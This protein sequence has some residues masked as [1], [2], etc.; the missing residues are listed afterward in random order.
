MYLGFQ[1]D[2]SN[3]VTN[4]I[5]VK[6]VK[7]LYYGEITYNKLQELISSVGDQ[8]Q[9]VKVNDNT[10]FYS[11]QRFDQLTAIVEN[12]K[13]VSANADYE[14]VSNAYNALSEALADFLQNGKNAGGEPEKFNATDLT[15]EK[16]HEASEFAR[17]DESITSRFAKPKYWTVEN[18]SIP[19]GGS[20]TKQGLDKYP[21]Y[22]C[23]MLGLWDD[24]DSNEEGDLANARIYQRI[25]LD[26]GRYYFGNTFQTRYNLGRA[27]L[28]AASEPVATS[29]M[30]Q[31]SLAWLNI[32]SGGDDN[33]FNGIYFTLDQT[34]D[35]CLGFQANLADGSGQQEFRANKVVLYGYNVDTGIE[36][37]RPNAAQRSPA[38]Y[39]SLSG[40]RLQQAPQHGFYIVRE[41]GKTR[42]MI[43]S[44]QK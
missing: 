14:T 4:N 6:A 22:D 1:A 20:G 35:V 42:K 23:L 31:Q 43:A 33:K 15:E 8:L 16:L 39:Y 13:A 29:E 11:K 38:A 10:G 21:G 34:Q 25:H 40:T 3:S 2:F 17:D 7:L 41:G 28:F 32:S 5:R 30:E 24:R 9:D 19:N 27:Y 37:M 18:F 12:A 26:A 36:E 44:P